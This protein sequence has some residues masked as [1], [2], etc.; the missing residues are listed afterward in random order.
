MSLVL[1]KSNNIWNKQHYGLDE[2][3]YINIRSRKTPL[4]H[5]DESVKFIV[6]TAA[7]RFIYEAGVQRRIA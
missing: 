3:S 5:T 6:L 4:Q 1:Y 2:A 7:V